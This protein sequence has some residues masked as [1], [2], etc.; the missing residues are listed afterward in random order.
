MI[1]ACKNLYLAGFLLVLGAVFL[2]AGVSLYISDDPEASG[3][4]CDSHHD[5]LIPARSIKILDDSRS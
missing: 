2:I 5:I 4:W 1:D 3:E